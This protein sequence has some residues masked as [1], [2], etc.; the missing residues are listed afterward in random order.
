MALLAQQDLQVSLEVQD[1]Q[2]QLVLAGTNWYRQAQQ[3]P[4]AQLVQLVQLTLTIYLLV[5]Y[6]LVECSL[7]HIGTI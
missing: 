3:E 7:K 1:L 4:Q 2:V 6:F 5:E